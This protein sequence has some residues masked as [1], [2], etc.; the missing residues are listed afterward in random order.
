V[1]GGPPRHPVIAAAATID[2]TTVRP[3]I[4]I[5]TADTFRSYCLTVNSMKLHAV[6]ASSRGS[7]L[8]T[9]N[10]MRSTHLAKH[11]AVIQP[12]VSRIAVS[13]M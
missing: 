13:N 4:R 1:A 2:T 6:S 9:E 8:N 12:R 5:V 11:P 3:T 7:S 10:V